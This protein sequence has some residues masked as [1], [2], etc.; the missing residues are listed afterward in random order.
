MRIGCVRI[1]SLTNRIEA[2]KLL[3]L[4][5]FVRVLRTFQAHRTA[6]ESSSEAHAAEAEQSR[7]DNPMRV[8]TV[9]LWLYHSYAI[10]LAKN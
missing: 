4:A 5:Q 3:N 7:L 1:N 6:L 9:S 10:V 2:H 8:G